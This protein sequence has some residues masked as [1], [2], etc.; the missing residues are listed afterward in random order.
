MVNK[1]WK[2]PAEWGVRT[3]AGG[4]WWWIIKLQRFADPNACTEDELS[5]G[6]SSWAK[7]RRQEDAVSLINTLPAHFVISV[8][9]CVKGKYKTTQWY[10]KVSYPDGLLGRIVLED[11]D[12]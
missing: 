8:S 5:L 4:A 3:W 12:G 11:T 7:F 1:R 9:R 10:D 6:Y 2:K